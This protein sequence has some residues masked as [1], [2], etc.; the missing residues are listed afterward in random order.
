MPVGGRIQEHG[1][2]AE[3]QK[4]GDV[5]YSVNI[6]VDGERVHRVIGRESDGIIREQAERAIESFRTKA[7]EGRLDLPTGRKRHRTFAEAA[8]EYLE[9]LETNGGKNVKQKRRHL[10]QHLVPFIGSERLDKLTEFRLRRYRK[11][12]EEA[13]AKPATVN[14]ELATLSHLMNRAASKEWRWI[15]ADDKPEIPRVVE[16]RKPIDILTPAQT[17]ALM[18]AAVADQDPDLWLFVLFGLN[19]A[20]RHSEIVCRR[21]DELDWDNCRL[22]IGKAKAGARVQP[23]TP[24]LRD[25]LKRRRESAEDQDGWI[26]PSRTKSAKRPHR[27]SLAKSFRR[28]VVRAKLNPAKVTPHTMRHTGISRLVMAGADIATIQKISGH[29]TVQMVMHYA[30]VFGS[31]IDSAIS[32]LDQ[33][34][35]D[36][37]APELHTGA[38]DAPG[39]DEEAHNKVVSISG[40]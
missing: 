7:R 21:F 40:P 17:A 19:T 32:I 6:M 8:D 26:F 39:D 4:N 3:R 30:H 12:R 13:G 27:V 33:Q 34:I 24:A 18:K 25:A 22:W 11:E 1:I 35:P 28:A 16:A 5:R 10:E 31:H 14:R 23:I 15:R 38:A 36:T 2:T 9:K 20:M 37:I 29:K